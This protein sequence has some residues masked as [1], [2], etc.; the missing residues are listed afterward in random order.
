M[1]GQPSTTSELRLKIIKALESALDPFLPFDG[2]PS[3]ELAKYD[4]GVLLP[5][6]QP[7]A[8]GE[9]H[10][11]LLE[12]C[13]DL[14]GRI[15]EEL[16]DGRAAADRKLVQT[17][18]LSIFQK[19]SDTYWFDV[20]R[21]GSD[22]ESSMRQAEDFF[23]G[24]G[25]GIAPGGLVRLL[26]RIQE[27]ASLEHA[28]L[29]RLRGYMHIL[30][31]R[32][33]IVARRVLELISDANHPLQIY[34][35][36]LLAGL[37]TREPAARREAASKWLADNNI[38]QLKALAASYSWRD[39]NLDMADVRI[40][41]QLVEVNDPDLDWLLVHSFVA[42][43]GIA[44]EKV[45]A[46]LLQLAQRAQ[47]QTYSKLLELIQPEDAPHGRT[48]TLHQTQ[49]GVFQQIVLVGA[50]MDFANQHGSGRA[51]GK[52]LERLAD[53]DLKLLLEFVRQRKAYCEVE[54]KSH[55]YAYTLLPAEADL[56]FASSKPD[57]DAFLEELLSLIAQDDGRG[58]ASY[59]DVLES[60][61]T[62]HIRTLPRI[63]PEL[64]PITNDVLCRWA[65][66]SPEQLRTVLKVLSRIH[67]WQSWFGIMRHI[68][69]RLDFTELG[70]TYDNL[71][72]PLF[73]A[74]YS[75]STSHSRQLLE[76]TRR[77]RRPD[78]SKQIHE[79]LGHIE[80]RLQQFAERKA[81]REQPEAEAELPENDD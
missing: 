56:R 14:L 13:S 22:I 12:H 47:S 54:Q 74:T 55:R 46:A 81:E 36:S 8:M 26:T 31:A 10:L 65:S 18:L 57:Y 19:F 17:N 32:D 37:S 1:Y 23:A 40:L 53:Q 68:V 20:R 73:A 44:P 64:D 45:G 75:S 61:L 25:V 33:A 60:I 78:D 58:S 15:E 2:T 42:V 72:S 43:E 6:I 50:R 24:F 34:V 35:S 62:G 27:D 38:T 9:R 63:T 79:F 28:E 11:V 3:P 49:P 4:A 59:V 69:Q 77:Q 66:G 5:R 21:V 29:W 51:L 7:I 52:C 39:D 16:I 76:L 80:M 30:G 67:P 41:E 71:M 48:Y 70:L